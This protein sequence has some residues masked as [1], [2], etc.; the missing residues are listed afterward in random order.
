MSLITNGSK[1]ELINP[2]KTY[3]VLN[4]VSYNC[5]Y[6]IIFCTKYRRKVLVDD[7]AADLKKIIEA[8]Q[9]EI[10]YRIISLDIT[11]DHVHLVSEVNPEFS[12]IAVIS[13][14]KA[15]SSHALREKYAVLRS[16]IPTLWT[17]VNFI[18][19]IGSVALSDIETFIEEQ[20][21][22]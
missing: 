2:P 8:K 20:K 19:T 15:A 10:G 18:S 3:R 1:M 17:R 4:N 16:R 11:A 5:Q 7:I 6:H 22:R 13:R 9:E 12:V 14:I 21:K